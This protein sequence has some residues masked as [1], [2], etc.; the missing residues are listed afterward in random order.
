MKAE[1]RV[2]KAGT[3]YKPKTILD[4]LIYFISILPYN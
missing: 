4:H 3:A 2:F 1:K